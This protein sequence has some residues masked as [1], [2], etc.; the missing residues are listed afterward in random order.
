MRRD[1]RG[2]TLAEATVALLVAGLLT[3]CFAGIL[4]A[5]GRVAVRYGQTAGAAETERVVAAIL[6]AELRALT[7]ADAAFGADSVRMR[8]FRGAGVVCAASGPELLIAYRG[9]RLPEEDK[10]SVLLIWSDGERAVDLEASR[11]A[12]GCGSSEESTL[13]V[14]TDR[15]PADTVAPALA[16]VFETGTYSIGGSAFRYRRGA[17]GRQPLTEQNLSSGGSSLRLVRGADGTAAAQV[18][19]RAVEARRGPA[20]SWRLRMVQGSARPGARPP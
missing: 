16:L 14:V 20:T 18:T 12:D 15:S 17:A 3:L 2:Y 9:V 8:A 11:A 13:R 4:A 5:V 7:A 6:G 10:D 1:R 19:L